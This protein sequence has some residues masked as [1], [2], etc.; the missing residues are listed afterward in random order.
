[1]TAPATARRLSAYCE[2]ATT[3]PKYADEHMHCR[4]PYEVRLAPVP[5]ATRGVLIMSVR[6]DC[7]C[8]RTPPDEE[9]K[10]NDT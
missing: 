1:M 10:A 4:G 7:D 6:C 3:W 5:P 2:L 8:H 9:L